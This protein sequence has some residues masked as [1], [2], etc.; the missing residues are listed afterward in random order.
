MSTAAVML[1][2]DEEDIVADTVRH[3]LGQVDA[4]IVSDNASTDGTR[5][6]LDAIHDPRLTVLDDPEVG[7]WQ[8]RKTSGLALLALGMGHRWVV[9]CDADEFWYATDGRR[10]ADFLAGITPDVYVVDALLYN[11]FPT[12]RDPKPASVIPPFARLGWRLPQHGA[13]PKVA[14]RAATDLVIE[15][16]NHGASYSEPVLRGGGLALRHY[17]WR[18]PEQYVKKILNGT[19]AYA[20]TDLPDDVGNHWRMWG[21]DPDP[22][23]IA[24]HFWRHFYYRDPVADGLVFDP[25]PAVA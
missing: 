3:L 23:R 9:P 19:R 13:L 15:A 24:F 1:V 6:K 16:G 12:G 25:A 4:V 14:C 10:I 20:A 7:Y 8:S 17:S 21:P 11:H 2:K 5:E 22:E 18:T